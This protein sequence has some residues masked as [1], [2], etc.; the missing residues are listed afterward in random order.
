MLVK[1]TS[2][3]WSNDRTYGHTHFFPTYEDALD[4]IYILWE[5]EITERKWVERVIG[6]QE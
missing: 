1:R 2:W 5:Y 3:Q 6:S 4:A